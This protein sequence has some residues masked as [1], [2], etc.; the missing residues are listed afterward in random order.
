MKKI[1]YVIVI[2][3][4]S[5]LI[6]AQE[7]LHLNQVYHLTYTGSIDPKSDKILISKITVPENKVWKIVSGTIYTTINKI[8]E[9]DYINLMIDNQIIMWNS[10]EL[11]T[12]TYQPIWLGKGT[13][14]IESCIIDRRT[15][16]FVKYNIAL[17]VIEYNVTP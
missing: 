6:R 13:Y 10:K 1:F 8:F 12:P 3:M 11:A 2:I 16:A 9:R 17:S 5:N 4:F 15:I 7:N 14:N